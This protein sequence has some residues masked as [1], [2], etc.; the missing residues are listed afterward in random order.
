MD[1]YQEVSEV[2]DTSGQYGATTSTRKAKTTVVA[3]DGQTIVIGGLIKDKETKSVSKVPLL[4]DIPLLGWFFRSTGTSKEKVNLMI[5]IT[6][7][8]IHNALDAERVS[9]K[10]MREIRE[11]IMRGGMKEPRAIREHPNL[12]DE[13]F[14]APPDSRQRQYPEVQETPPKQPESEAAPPAEEDD[15][16]AYGP[17][18]DEAQGAAPAA[19]PRPAPKTKKN[20][21]FDDVQPP[22][23]E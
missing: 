16:G 12:Q 23:S 15:G 18:G 4:G 8:I 7:H 9:R 13:S 19:T 1:I 14:R 5:Y 6:P 22:T 21:P 11:S 3:S 20:S 10:K 17:E 2:K